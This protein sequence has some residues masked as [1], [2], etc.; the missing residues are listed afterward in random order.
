MEV[1]ERIRAQ[2][3][4]LT[5]A[6]RRVAEVVLSAPQSIGFGTVADLAQTAGVGAASVV[7]LATKL[8]FDGYSE[9]QQAVQ[10]E[11]TRQLRPAAE[12]IHQADLGSRSEH[13]STELDNVSGT[14]AGVDDAA[15]A[16]V[17]ARLADCARPIAVVAGDACAGVAQVF[18]SQLH[19]LRAGVV[20]ICGSEVAVRRD[21]AVLPVEASVVVVDL[22]RYEQWVLDAHEALAARGLWSVAVTDSMLSPLASVADVAF[23]AAA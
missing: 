2:G 18:V 11:L 12:R 7:R 23:V 16:N 15:M 13:A 17:V 4:A 20:Q 1:A 14:L 6:E 10:D 5:T 21:L 8:G 3:A 22:R 19:Q 9:L